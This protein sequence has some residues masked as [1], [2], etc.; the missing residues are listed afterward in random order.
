MAL[1]ASSAR[2]L[3]DAQ[4]EPHEHRA[5][6]P[7]TIFRDQFRL[8]MS[9]AISEEDAAARLGWPLNDLRRFESGKARVTG[10]RA[11]ALQGVTGAIAD[12]WEG[13]QQEY[14]RTRRK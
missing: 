14:D 12:F 6:H 5:V 2:R 11:S 10:A 1:S 13:L 4:D 8:A 7:G 3:A 9:P